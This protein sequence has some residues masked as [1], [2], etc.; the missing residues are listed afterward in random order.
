[1][2]LRM[3]NYNI[4]DLLDKVLAGLQTHNP[5]YNDP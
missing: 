4:N 3:F 2:A 1:M 5:K